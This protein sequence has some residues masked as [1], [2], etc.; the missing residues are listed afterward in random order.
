MTSA[1]IMGSAVK[2]PPDK[3]PPPPTKPDAGP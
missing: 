3:P 1:A 2:D